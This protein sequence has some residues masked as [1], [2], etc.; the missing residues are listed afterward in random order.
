MCYCRQRERRAA[1]AN[2]RRSI[3]VCIP[4]FRPLRLGSPGRRQGIKGRAPAPLLRPSRT[5]QNNITGAG[6]SAVTRRP[7]GLSVAA[8]VPQELASKHIPESA[9]HRNLQTQVGT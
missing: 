9:P 1:R 4:I 6:R 3:A 7:S 5:V 2:H 8:S